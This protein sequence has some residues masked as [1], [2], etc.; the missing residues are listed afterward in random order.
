MIQ[1]G[2]DVRMKL[3]PTLITQ[4]PKLA[5]VATMALGCDEIQAYH[6]S[7]IEIGKDWLVEAVWAGDFAAG[8]FDK[9][10]LVF[11]TGIRIRGNQVVFV[12]SGTMMD[13]LY[14]C[15]REQQWFIGN[16]LPAVLACSGMS[17]DDDYPDYPDDIRSQ[18]GGL[19]HYKRSLPTVEGK[20]QLTYYRNIQYNG[21]E[22]VEIDKPNTAPDF[23]SYKKYYDFLVATADE[24]RRNFESPSRKYGVQPLTTVSKG[25]DSCAVA[26]IVGEAGVKQSVTIENASS[27]LPR[28][29][30][31]VEIANHLGLSC[32]TYR[33]SPVNYRYEEAIWAA[34][35]DPAGLNLTIFNY[36]DELSVFFTGYR[37]DSLWQRERQD[38]SQP[39]RARSMDG[40]SMTEFRLHAGVFHCPVPFWGCLNAEEIQ[41]IGFSKEMAPWT[42]GSNYDR[43]IPR[44]ILE[45]S[46]VPRQSFGIRKGATFAPRSFFWPFGRDSMESFREYL[47]QRGLYA[48]N[49]GTIWLLRKFAHLDQ[50]ISVNLSHVMGR[51]FHGLR[52]YFALRGQKLLFQWAN[53]TLKQRYVDALPKTNKQPGE[54]EKRISF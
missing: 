53:N 24:L 52:P 43:P 36:P 41:E 33:H 11:G 7:Y 6:G 27:L 22:L 50:L 21:N 9:T 39:F 26:A 18:M 48:P 3:T 4:W 23:T 28:T 37:G 38:R 12:S 40:L 15:Q 13:R 2:K 19:N 35:G 20:V 30:S 8:D 29:D 1:R 34:A 42:L 25:Y 54:E 51:R 46:G 47:H 32:Q 5:W 31:G 10:E 45:D 16:S 14:R 44:R 49:C 17:L